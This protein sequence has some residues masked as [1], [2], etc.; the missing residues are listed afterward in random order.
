[1][2]KI[3]DKAL[4]RSNNLGEWIS[5]DVID[6]EYWDV[7]HNIPKLIQDLETVVKYVCEKYAKNVL[8]KDLSQNEKISF[9]FFLKDEMEQIYTTEK[10]HL[11]TRVIS[12]SNKKPSPRAK[13]Q[14]ALMEL[15]R[16]S[17]GCPVKKDK[18]KKMAYSS[19][20]ETLLA[21]VI[22]SEATFI[23]K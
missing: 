12:K 22:E 2:Y 10:N 23:A 1:M 20:F 19:V 14:P 6:Y 5:P 17:N 11:Q 4:V 13:E 21:M 8:F 18:I 3:L 9:Y 15:H 7:R 16:L